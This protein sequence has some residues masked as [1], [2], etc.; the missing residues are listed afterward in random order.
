VEPSQGKLGLS[1]VTHIISNTIDFEQYTEAQALMIP[2][3][4]ELWIKTSTNKGK[5]AQLRPYSP[6]PRL[7]FSNV[8]VSCADIPVTDRESIVGAV[9]ALGGTE[10]KDLSRLTTHIC[11]LSEDNAK[12]QE[13]RRKCPNCKVVLPH[14]YVSWSSPP[15]AIAFGS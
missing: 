10:S 3:V 12:V 1:E 8:V 4:T 6:D 14:W 2:V 11:A 5:Q 15:Q 13:A 9:M 7:I